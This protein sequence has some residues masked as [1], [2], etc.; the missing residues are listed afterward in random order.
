MLCA[1]LLLW[2]LDAQTHTEDR[3]TTSSASAELTN[4][5]VKL[6]NEFVVKA[7][8]AFF[9]IDRLNQHLLD[10]RETSLSKDQLLELSDEKQSWLTQM[11]G[12]ETVCD[13]AAA[14]A[15]T[16]QEKQ[17]A[18]IAEDTVRTIET[19][20]KS[21]EA[22][23]ELAVG[24]ANIQTMNAELEGI[25]GPFLAQTIAL[26]MHDVNRVREDS[27]TKSAS[28]AKSYLAAA[29]IVRARQALESGLADDDMSKSCAP[30][31]Q[32]D[33]SRSIGPSTE[34]HPVSQ[35]ERVSVATFLA[36]N[37]GKD[38]DVRADGDTL[39]WKLKSAPPSSPEN[40][41]AEFKQ[42]SVYKEPGLTKLRSVGFN[43]VRLEIG[44]EAF[45]WSIRP[46]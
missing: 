19:H 28:A 44:D 43:Q 13:E 15:T 17:I 10:L 18:Q 41:A 27:S 30:V 32:D 31:T 20:H 25:A 29:C 4:H 36:T 38:W 40:F 3:P 21:I 16:A 24:A 7:K 42:N 11:S 33:L 5:K 1:I 35:D 34:N 23:V 22:A 8:Q 9:A 12:A 39:I 14:L 46:H 45:V 26:G 6:S 2:N 37:A